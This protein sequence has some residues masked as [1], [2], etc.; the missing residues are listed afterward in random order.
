MAQAK[1]CRIV[2]MGTPD[3]GVASL[4]RLARWNGGE[5]VGVYTQPDRPAGRGH[6][7]CMPP[8]KKCALELGYPVFQP[9]SLKDISEQKILADLQPD[10]IAVAAYGLILPEA[11]LHTP[12]L[13]CV[14]VHASLLPA[15]RGAAPI[16]RAVI[17]SWRPGFRAGVTIMR[18]TKMLDSGPVFAA[19]SVLVDNHT[20]GSLHDTLAD[21]GAELLITVLDDIVEG[22][23]N[24]EPQDDALATYAPK[25]TKKD[26]FIE[27]NSPAAMVH[28]RI[29]GVTP[30]PGAQVLL[31]FCHNPASLPLQLCIAPGIISDPVS[32]VL[33]GTLVKDKKSLRIACSD[34]WYELTRIR[35]QGCGDM[36]VQDIL[37]GQLRTIPQGVC[38]QALPPNVEK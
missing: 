25:I 14:N 13:D 30:K 10:F 3:F 17:D 34:F 31:D 4:K 19:D 11:V 33:P 16:Q 29:R 15:Y 18:I 35:P 7:I 37:N 8:V 36:S 38:G 24:P 20:S 6:R 32:D 23:A 1:K 22:N 9:H 12:K 27:W 21:L 28:A 2:F 5:I 26:S